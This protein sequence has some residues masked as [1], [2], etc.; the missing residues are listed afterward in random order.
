MGRL[1]MVIMAVV[2]TLPLLADP[3]ILN[4]TTVSGTVVLGLGPPVYALMFIK[5]YRPLVFHLPFWSGVAFGVVFQLSTASCCRDYINIEG[6]R[7][8]SGSE[9]ALLGFNVIG[10]IVAWGL[11][12]VCLLENMPAWQ[13]D[14]RAGSDNSVLGQFGGWFGRGRKDVPGGTEDHVGKDEMFETVKTADVEM[15]GAAR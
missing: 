6:F 13:L 4:A 8:G 1:A 15:A 3:K 9:A 7:F 2:G 11:C 12:G 10:S 5:G 14:R